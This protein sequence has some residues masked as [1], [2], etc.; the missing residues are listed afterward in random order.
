MKTRAIIHWVFLSS[1]T[2]TGGSRAE[3]LSRAEA[4]AKAVSAN[5]E[6]WKSL[7]Q[8]A[9]YQGRVTEARADALPDVS[10]LG[11]A[12][13]YR[14]PSL[15]NSSA[16]DSF[17]PEL[18]DALKPTPANLYE[19]MFQVRQTIWSFKLG[20]ALRAA[21]EGLALGREGITLAERSTAIATIR[22]YNDYLLN[23][24]K[25]KVALKSVRLL[26]THLDMART[27]WHAGVATELD[28]LRSQVELENEKA[29]FERIRGQSDLALSGLN[30]MMVRRLDTPIEPT[31]S[32]SYE[33]MVVEP[34]E[35]IRDALEARPE[36]RSLDLMQKI[37]NEL[38][39]LTQA[40]S[41]PRVDFTLN[42][43][44]SVR[45][46]HNF[47]DSDFQRW[48]AGLA[49][50]VP[51]F[52]GECTRGR[53]AQAVA[54]REKTVQDRIA[55]ENQIRLDAKDA[56]D[57]L[58]VARRVLEAAELNVSQAQRALDMTQ[59]NYQNGAATTLDVMDGQAALTLAE[60]LRI[61][62]LY[63]HANAR[64][65]V[66]Y[67]MGRDPL[68]ASQTQPASPPGK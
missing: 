27:R 2:C 30:A 43:G 64:S 47:F 6:V 17:P 32:L 23:I 22:A 34:D 58:H 52:D 38:I 11:T 5:P 31:D 63:D 28:V 18:R 45:K 9:S 14:D 42:W 53:V 25:V 65:T 57:R 29:Q 36:V 20:R 4:V 12:T 68:G 41:R 10:F 48:S 39:G 55:L 61:E 50:T 13:R 37:E 66:L 40:D 35:V 8:L 62:A 15:L 26:E 60:S 19:G 16:F 46:P 44:Y 1:L 7:Q 49:V 24:E 21:R 59:A 54:E 33:P 3:P 51:I 56:V 67:V